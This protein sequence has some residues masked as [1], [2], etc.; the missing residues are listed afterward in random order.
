MVGL[1]ASTFLFIAKIPFMIVMGIANSHWY[2]YG[3]FT[4]AAGAI[5]WMLAK[6]VLPAMDLVGDV[7]YYLGSPA[8]RAR[9]E[10]NMVEALESVAKLAPNAT[11]LAV[12]HSLDTVLVAQSMSKITERREG[13]IKIFGRPI[14]IPVGH[15]AHGRMIL[16]TLGSPL[17]LLSRIF[18]GYVLSPDE[19]TFAFHT[20]SSIL[21]WANLWRDRDPIGRELSPSDQRKFAEKSIG[22][23]Y[24]T[25]IFRTPTL[26]ISIASV[27]QALEGGDLGRLKADWSKD[28]IAEQEAEWADRVLSALRTVGSLC[29]LLAAVVWKVILPWTRKFPSEPN[30]HLWLVCTLLICSLGITIYLAM[31]IN[32]KAFAHSRGIRTSSSR[33]LLGSVRRVVGM[34][35]VFV[36]ISFLLMGLLT[37]LC[38]YSRRLQLG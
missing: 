25:N 16:V 19:L 20:H 28:V 9:I 12:A 13:T 34:T 27:L 6:V 26:W 8:R 30:L 17:R 24:H 11:I 38:W 15:L 29:A 33:Q 4:L 18:Q 14:Q 5:G 3:L 22:D 31:S 2:R 21:F 36:T 37:V 10:S 23:G 7:A 32:Q 1:F 35:T